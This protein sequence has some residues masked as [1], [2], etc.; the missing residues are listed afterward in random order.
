MTRPD[1]DRSAT[2]GGIVTAG[3][4][5]SEGRVVSLVGTSAG[6]IDG[7]LIGVWL[8][9]LSSSFTLAVSS[10]SMFESHGWINVDDKC[11]KCSGRDDV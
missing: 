1:L 6:S 9:L 4:I 2:E 11:S 8:S 5:V 10:S 3:V 7:S